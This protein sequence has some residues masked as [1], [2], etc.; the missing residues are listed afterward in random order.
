LVTI[1]K[2]CV[3]EDLIILAVGICRKIV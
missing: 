2:S 3:R 1:Q